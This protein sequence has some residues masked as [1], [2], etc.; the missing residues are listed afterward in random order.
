[1]TDKEIIF[2]TL[3]EIID[4]HHD[5]IELYG[6]IEGIRDISLL[7]SAI[8]IPQS[9]FDGYFL[10]DDLF[11]MASAYIYHLCQNHPYVDGNKRVALVTG[12]IFLDFNG[13]I[14]D[15]PDEKLYPMMMKVASGKINKD[16]ISN[17]LK[18]LNSSK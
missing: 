8:S 18:E 3:A 11:E 14:I 2:L 9:T 7:S 4:I 6:G 15:D 12:L 5:Q 13:I 17:I 16:G 1:M 10:H